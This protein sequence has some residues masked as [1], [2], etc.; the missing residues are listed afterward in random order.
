MYGGTSGVIEAAHDEAPS[1]GVPRP[2]G[3]GAVD[4]G[5]PD[6]HEQADLGETASFGESSAGEGDG[7]A[8]EHV[9]DCAGER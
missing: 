5:E 2:A 9:L 8:G 4:D 6:E 3:D 1:L 7:D